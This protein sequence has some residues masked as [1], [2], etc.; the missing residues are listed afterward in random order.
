M[1]P[2]IYSHG[3]VFTNKASIDSTIIVKPSSNATKNL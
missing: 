3:A 2:A 1:Q